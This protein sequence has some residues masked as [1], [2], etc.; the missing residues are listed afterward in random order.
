[1]N[2]TEQPFTRS[3][4]VSIGEEAA[5]ALYDTQWWIG[6]TPREIAER[7][8][9]TAE[10]CCPFGVFHEALEAAIGR[11]VWTHELALNFEGIARELFNGAPAPTMQEIVEL[12]PAEKRIVVE[13]KG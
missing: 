8:M 1:M 6:K 3:K 9:A 10:L 13:L 12:I 11:P 5:I 7:Q 4:Q 2:T